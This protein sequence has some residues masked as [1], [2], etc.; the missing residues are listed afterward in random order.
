MPPVLRKRFT[1]LPEVVYLLTAPLKFGRR[2]ETY[3][4]PPETAMSVSRL[5]PV[6]SSRFT[7]AP[8][9]VYGQRCD[10]KSVQTQRWGMNCR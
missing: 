2:P 5:N 4:K 1:S 10:V 9:V 6:I 3:R 7:A 8:E